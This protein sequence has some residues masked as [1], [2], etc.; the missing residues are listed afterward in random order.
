MKNLNSSGQENL[1]IPPG[2]SPSLNHL[3]PRDSR[4][5]VFQKVAAAKC[6]SRSAWR[7]CVVENKA[8]RQ[9]GQ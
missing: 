4:E 3:M 6:L 8:G 5:Q 9:C 7:M 2:Q 1:R